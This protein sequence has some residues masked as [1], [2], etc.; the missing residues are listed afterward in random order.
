MKRVFLLAM[1]LAV[2]AVAQE[3]PALKLTKEEAK[4]G[5]YLLLKAQT[6]SQKRQEIVA[7]YQKQLESDPEFQAVKAQG[8]V[9]GAEATKL[10]EGILAKRKLDPKT[11]VV[12]LQLEQVEKIQPPANK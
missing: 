4:E 7:K 12:N 10:T 9:I 1:I 8:E 5:A 2:N 6:L 11:H 3:A